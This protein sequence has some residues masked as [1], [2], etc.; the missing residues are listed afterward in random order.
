MPAGDLRG[1]YADAWWLERPFD[2]DE[3]PASDVRKPFERDRDRIVHS[4]A[5]RRLGG[6]TQV[7]GSP[8]AYDFRNSGAV[9][10]D[11]LSPVRRPE[12]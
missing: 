11:D 7:I 10:D 1:L 3:Q 2:E 8:G 9:G 5:L 6:K 12:P 4:R